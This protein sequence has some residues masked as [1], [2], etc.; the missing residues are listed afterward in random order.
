MPS[1]RSIRRSNWLSLSEIRSAS[2]KAALEQP[3]PLAGGKDATQRLGVQVFEN[4]SGL[5]AHASPFI[6]REQKDGVAHRAMAQDRRGVVEHDD[7]EF[8]GAERLRRGLD[9]RQAQIEPRGR[10]QPVLDPDG[11]V[12]VGERSSVAPRSRSDQVRDE[13]RGTIQRRGEPRS[14]GCVDVSHGCVLIDLRHVN[15]IAR[16]PDG[17]YSAPERGH[18]PAVSCALVNW[19]SYVCAA[20]MSVLALSACGGGSQKRPTGRRAEANA[21][22]ERAGVSTSAADSGA[23][24][25]AQGPKRAKGPLGPKRP[26]PSRHGPP[27]HARR[28]SAPLPK[29]NP[30]SADTLFFSG[31]ASRTL[32]TV[33]IHTLSELRWT[34]SEGRFEMLVGGQAVVDSTSRS[35]DVKASPKT[36]DRVK[37]V[38]PGPWTI[39][40]VP[41]SPRPPVTPAPRPAPGTSPGSAGRTRPVFFSASGRK[42]L[43][44]LTISAPG[45]LRWTDSGAR[46]RLTYQ[47]SAAVI[48]STARSGSLPVPAGT[49]RDVQVQ[50]GGK[51]TIRIG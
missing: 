14:G 39:H 43:G 5:L 28:K 34:S 30:V 23:S 12:H 36:Y 2:T 10:R 9:E 26:R 50:A 37:V 17:R 32:G 47:G 19:R 40:I 16:T 27:R 1:K 22:G 21:Q 51:W 42:S 48:D 45:T 44:N 6:V 49:Y 13:D 7:V 8:A 29:G 38:A 46:F 31:S 4:R 18:L 25:S 24:A 3:P 33:A 41:V 15:M 20:V 35:G 11:H